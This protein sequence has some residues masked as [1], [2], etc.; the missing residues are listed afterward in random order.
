[1]LRVG[2]FSGKIYEQKEHDNFEI[3]ECAKA[4]PELDRDKAVAFSRTNFPKPECYE[5]KACEES[6][7]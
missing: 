7:K 4:F 1:M 2:L 6:Q 3:R 5:C